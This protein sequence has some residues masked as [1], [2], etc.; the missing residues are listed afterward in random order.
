MSGFYLFLRRAPE[1][2]TV[3]KPC[4]GLEMHRTLSEKI[5]V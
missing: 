4:V 1:I 2:A 5:R 3:I